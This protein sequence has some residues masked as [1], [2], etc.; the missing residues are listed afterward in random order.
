[1]DC[2]VNN[3]KREDNRQIKAGEEGIM[4]AIIMDRYWV[5]MVII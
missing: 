2:F 4:H 3:I 1:V 5:N